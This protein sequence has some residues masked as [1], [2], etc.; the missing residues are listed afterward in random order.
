VVMKSALV[1]ADVVAVVEGHLDIH[2]SYTATAAIRAA[3][4]VQLLLVLRILLGIV[5]T[6]VAI[7]VI[8]IL[9][10]DMLNMST[11]GEM[12]GVSMERVVVPLTASWPSIKPSKA[13]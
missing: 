5:A 9:N 4:S 2:A 6:H 10:V 11:A 12:E 13:T 1:V 3:Q 8:I 7:V